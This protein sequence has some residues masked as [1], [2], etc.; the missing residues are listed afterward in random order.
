[1]M[2]WHSRESI[3]WTE[4]TRKAPIENLKKISIKS[5]KKAKLKIESNLF[6]SIYFEIYVIFSFIYLLIYLSFLVKW[7]SING[8]DEKKKKKKTKTIIYN[9]LLSDYINVSFA[10]L[11]LFFLFFFFSFDTDKLAIPHQRKSNA[12][13]KTVPT[14]S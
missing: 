2:T 5:F 10:N 1:M 9:T 3:I 7:K 12:I 4:N 14:Y 11:S 6:W 8:D 13:Y